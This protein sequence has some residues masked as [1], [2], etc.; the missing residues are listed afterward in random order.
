V[1]AF[2]NTRFNLSQGGESRYAEALYVTA[3]YFDLLGVTPFLGRA[4][5]GD[6]EKR[7]CNDPGVV[8]SYAFWQR[9]FAGD[10]SAVGRSISLDGRN[11]SIIGIAPKEFFGLEPARRFDLV[12]PLCADTVLARHPQS[13]RMYKSD[14]WWLTIIV[15]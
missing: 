15:V 4:L 9:E 1:L 11:F 3:N 2:N 13:R 10:A 12:V 14:A 6:E 7:E 5:N 8:L